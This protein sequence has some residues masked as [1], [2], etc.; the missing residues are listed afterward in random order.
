MELKTARLT[1][2]IDPGK[3]QA[4]EQLCRTQDLTPSQVVRRLIREYME[5]QEAAVP[6]RR[7]AP[8]KAAAPARR[9]R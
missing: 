9:A 4:F 7:A 6:V 1:I 3:K 8:R 5:Q 2:L